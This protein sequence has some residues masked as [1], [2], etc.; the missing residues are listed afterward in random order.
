V[1]FVKVGD[2]YTAHLVRVGISDFD[3]TEVLSGVTEGERVA[4]LGAAVLQAQREQQQQRIRA[5][6][7]GG[8]QQ[9][10]T[11]AAGAGGAG[12]AG[13]AGGAGGASGRGP[14]G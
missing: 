5:G 2:K 4:L 8:L 10:Q 11:P 7:G 9:Q 6:T 1:V 3:Y 14:G 12:G 13:R